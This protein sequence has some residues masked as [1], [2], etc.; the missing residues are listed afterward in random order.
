VSSTRPTW[1]VSADDP[2]HP[3]KVV[4][5]AH[6]MDRHG[7]TWL[8]GPLVAA[9]LAELHAMLPAGLTTRDRVPGDPEWAVEIWD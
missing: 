9:T 7:G 5:R 6:S 8:P 2:A 3:G 1:Y 4:A